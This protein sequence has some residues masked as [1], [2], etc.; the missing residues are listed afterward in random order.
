MIKTREN[1]GPAELEDPTQASPG[2]LDL[3][4]IRPLK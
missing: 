2:A 1:V 3:S 4:P